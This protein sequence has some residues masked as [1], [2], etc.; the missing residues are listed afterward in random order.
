MEF[1]EF[2]EHFYDHVSELLAGQSVLFVADVD[3]DVL[4]DAYMESFPPG[5]NEVYRKR[6]EHDCSCCRH[7]IKDMGAVVAIKDNRLVT[8]WDFNPGGQFSPVMAALSEKVK[9]APIKDVFVTKFPQHGTAVSREQL[10]S[11]QVQTWNH[12][13]VDLPK[14]FVFNSGKSVP[15]ITGEFRDTKNVFRRSLEEISKEAIE[16]VLDLIAENTLYRGEEWAG[17]LAKFME[18][19]NQYHNLPASQK[20]N[21]C[22]SKSVEVGAAL[23]K[24]RNHSIGVLL[25][26]LTAGVEVD[27]AV[28]KYEHIV[29]PTNY[30]RPKAIFTTRM[31]EDAQKTVEGL[32]LLDSLGRRHA[33]LSD[34]TINNVLWANRDAVKHMYGGSGVFAAMKQEVSVNPR[35]Y[36][37]APGVSIADFVG[38]VLPSAAR[39]EVLLENRHQGNLVSLIAPQVSESPTLFKWDN[40]FSWAYA[41]NIADSMKQRVKAAGGNVDGVWGNRLMWNENNDNPNDLDL[42]VTEPNGN[43]IFFGRKNG[44]RSSGTLDV[45]IIRPAGVAVENI[46]YTNEAVMPE[47]VYTVF[48]HCYSHR[49]GRS[50]FDAEIEFG[51]QIFEFSYHKDIPQSAAVVVARVKFGH[52]DGFQIIESLPSSTSGRTAWELQTNQ[53]H[54]VSVFMYSPNYWDGQDGIGNR[55]YFFMLLGAKNDTQ[56]NGF[57]NEYLREE[58]MK[59]KNVFEALGGKMKVSPS[60]NQLSGLGFSSTKRDSL[61]VK[62]DDRMVRI[63]F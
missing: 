3:R 40:P 42:H 35:N 41:G 19:H 17:P 49:G 12:F 31:I 5:T 4:W 50:G 29:A 39:V 32:G 47:G 55:H 25:Q 21:F 36:E 60:D 52:K 20:D 10:E 63:V 13:H 14:T 7:F 22:W 24:I 23:G 45:D 48:V 16:S 28:R 58:F 9:A 26:D 46:V 27:E 1:N 37:S 18:L 62:V 38:N 8:I 44:H 53:F 59:H 51:G 6:R 30:K 34:I 33:V 2:K 43:E 57:F 54:P 61:I 15:E 56:P 11:G